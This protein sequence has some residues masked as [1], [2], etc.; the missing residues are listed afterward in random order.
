MFGEQVVFKTSALLTLIQVYFRYY[1][2]FSLKTLASI[3]LILIVFGEPFLIIVF[4]HRFHSIR[5][6]TS[7][8]IVHCAHFFASY[9]ATV[10]NLF[11]NL[12]SNLSSPQGSDN[13]LT[14][15][16]IRIAI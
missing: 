11:F 14:S 10:S 16:S 9:T 15:Y 8:F 4:D 3:A 13:K 6:F 5:V 12:F 7:K 2:V 1:R